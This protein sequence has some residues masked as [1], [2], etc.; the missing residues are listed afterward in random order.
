MSSNDIYEFDAWRLRVLSLAMLAAFALL[1][2]SLWRIQVGSGE[3]YQSS[4]EQQSIRRVRIPGMRGRIFDRSF[5]C[6][7]DNRPN[8]CIVL[9]LEELRPMGKRRITPSDAWKLIRRLS[10]LIGREPGVTQAQVEQ[11]LANRKALPL[12]VWQDVDER[13]LARFSETSEVFSGVDVFVD[14]KRVYPQGDIAGHLL[15]YVGRR[16]YQEDED[17]EKYHYYLPDLTGKR[18]IEKQYD[19][20]L[21]GMAGGR[22]V[23][24]DVSGF[25]HDEAGFQEPIAGGDIQ[26]AMDVRIQRIVEKVIGPIVGAV[27]VMDPRNGDVL[28]LASSPSFDPNRFCPYISTRDW[29]QLVADP[30]KPLVNRAVN[31]QYAPGSIF[32][33][34]VALAALES[35][36]A[37]ESTAF[38]CSG[39]FDLGSHRFDCFMKE[40]HGDLRI[41]GALTL[42]CNVYF[43]QLGILCGVDVIH[44]MGLAL[45]L[46]RKT[47]IDLPDESAGLL[48]SREWKRAALRDGWREGDSCNLAVGQGALLVTPL[49]MASMTAAIANG[50]KLFKPRLAVARRDRME[51]EFQLIEPVVTREL[52]WGKAHLTLVRDAMRDV[53]ESPIGTGQRARV[54]GVVMAGKTGTAEFGRK[55]HGQKHGWMI[56]FA[57]FDHPRYALAMVADEAVTGGSTV[58][59]LIRQIMAEVL[60]LADP[61]ESS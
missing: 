25:K 17:E 34:L 52:H 7:A 50:G 21:A 37:S 35:G 14:A 38:V 31:G 16:E 57:P 47:G 19:D 40:S 1:S 15:G 36:R 26:L 2:A 59:P 28:A 23:R 29:E 54:A 53:I 39:Y 6:L 58:G 45:G 60:A 8:Y 49:Q 51:S 41:G 10:F 43:Y 44:A 46:G 3:Q 22:L 48:P 56:V 12:V 9:Y 55:G 33:P 11:H 24:V 18:G 30:Q 13:T 20:V 42:S 27:V 32:K 4:I 61:G 5:A